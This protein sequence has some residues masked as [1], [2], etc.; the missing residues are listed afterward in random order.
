LKTGPKVADKDIR[1]EI[2][3]QEKNFKQATF[4]GRNHLRI[5]IQGGSKL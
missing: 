4:L 2:T 5:I 1:N 3:Q